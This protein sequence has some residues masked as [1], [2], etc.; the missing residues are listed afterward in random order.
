MTHVIGSVPE[1][2]RT[3]VL[4]EFRRKRYEDIQDFMSS[5]QPGASLTAVSL[6]SEIMVVKLF[7]FTD[8]PWLLLSTM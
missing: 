6:M 8:K 5:R 3:L 1:K 4:F 7:P 2:F